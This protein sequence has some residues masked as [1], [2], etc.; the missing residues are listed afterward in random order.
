MLVKN[1]YLSIF[2]P[3]LISFYLSII[4]QPFFLYFAFKNT[5][6]HFLLHFYLHTSFHF[7]CSLVLLSIPSFQI[8][9][10]LILSPFV[11]VFIHH[12]L[13]SISLSFLSSNLAFLSFCHRFSIFFVNQFG[14]ALIY[15]YVEKTCRLPLELKKLL[16]LV[17]NI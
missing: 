2:L 3:S 16:W 1:V 10:S 11:P 4:F 12:L 13:T 8:S 6:P 9:N 7:T 14:K 5:F 17:V 15:L